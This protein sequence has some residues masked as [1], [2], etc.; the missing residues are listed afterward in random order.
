MRPVARRLAL[1]LVASPML[2]TCSSAR[3]RVESTGETCIPVSER[4]GRE[5]GCFITATE[6]LGLLGDSPLFWHISRHPTR[7]AAEAVR[8]PGGTVVESL[9]QVW[10][11]TISAEGTWPAE[12]ERVAEIGPLPLRSG[13]PYVA[14]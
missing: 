9:G 3:E 11:F 4:V 14:Q 10:L 12:G 1:A 13:T 8:D 5:F 7:I 2:F 6:T